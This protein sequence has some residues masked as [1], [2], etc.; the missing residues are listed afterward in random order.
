MEIPP[1]KPHFFKPI[2][3]GFK[4]GLKIPLGFLKYL[5][6]HDQHEHAILTTCDKKWLGKVNGRRLEEGSW[7]EF[8]EEL[9]LKVGDVLVFKHEGD[10]EFDVFKFDSSHHCDKEY[11]MYQEE[12]EDEDEEDEDKL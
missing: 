1:K 8:V 9:N 11:A 5:K 10:M 12:D 6:R 2:L 7:I 3:P 4:N